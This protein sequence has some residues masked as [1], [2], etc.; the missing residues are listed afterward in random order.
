MTVKVT[1]VGLKGM[2]GYRVSVEVKVMHGPES[3]VIVGLPDASV[4]ESKERVAAALRSCRYEVPDQKV[5]VN[6]SPAEQKKNGPMFDL[7]VAIGLLGAMGAIKEE[8]KEDTGFIGALSLD[9]NVQPVEGML[10][11]V[12]AARKIGLKKLYLPYDPNLPAIDFEN[13]ELIY[14]TS[15][16]DVLDHLAGQS[17][18][19]FVSSKKESSFREAASPVR[20]EQIVGH[21]Y[22]KRAMEIAAAG[23]HHFFMIGPP[24]CGKSMLA[25][26]FT[27]ILPALSSQER[28]E[29]ISLHHLSG[30]PLST[31]HSRPLRAP[32]HSASSVS[33]I[34]GGQYPKP[35]EISLAHHGV[36]FLDEMAE[37]SKKT[38]D[39]LRQPIETGT[40]TISRANATV[41]YPSQFTLIGAMNPCPCG[42]LGSDKYYCTCSPKQISAYQNRLSGPIRDRLDIFLDI[43][44]VNFHTTMPV[45]D[46][47]DMVLTRVIEARRRQYNRYGN[48]V[49]NS[50]VS[51]D[52]LQSASPLSSSQQQLL[53]QISSKQHLSNR[54]QVKIIRL[55]RTISD[56]ENSETITEQSIWEALKLQNGKQ[57]MNHTKKSEKIT[58]LL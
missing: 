1:T 21:S 19:S 57:K 51:Y 35:G 24:G 23:G 36:L 54:T 39:M 55:A 9:G 2:D 7:A 18:F 17:I 26:S 58:H 20:F 14:V 43:Q 6:L 31:Q 5:I 30:V 28:L 42:Y 50:L 56:L 49:L 46:T 25:E 53:R 48:Q 41:N 29:V 13:I 40:V 27:S 4:K 12:L 11:A 33:I 16:Q 10:P 44:P 15:L 52:T 34:G 22:P 45:G 37:F 3:V 8:I 47:S 32:H 38:L